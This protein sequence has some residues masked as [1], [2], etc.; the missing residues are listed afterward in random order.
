MR[1]LI[2]FW[3]NSLYAI[4]KYTRFLC[5]TDP[6]CYTHKKCTYMLLS[7]TQRISIKSD[8]IP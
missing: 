8:G 3:A 1:M 4:E 5:A 2:D 6:T 7:G